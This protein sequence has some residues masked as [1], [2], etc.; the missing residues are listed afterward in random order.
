MREGAG[1]DWARL[2]PTSMISRL[3]SVLLI[4][5]SL[6]AA[7]VAVSTPPAKAADLVE[8]RG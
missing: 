2:D 5:A 8:I 6:I 7:T 3:V 1:A 4:T